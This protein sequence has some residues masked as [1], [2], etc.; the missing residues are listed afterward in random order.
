M[1]LS[2]SKYCNGLQ[3]PKMLW[4]ARNMPEQLDSSVI[5]QQ[6]LDNGSRVG[7]VAM[8]YFGDFVEV[9]YNEKK[10][11]M[12]TETR[13][14]MDSG[15]SVIAEA[16][17]GFDGNFCSVDLLRKCKDHYD[18]IEV[19]SST[20]IK[21][22]YIHDMAYQFYVLTNCGVPIEKIFIM[23]I[24]NEYIRQGA[25]DLGQLFILEDCTE[26]VRL[27]AQQVRQNIEDIKKVAESKTE[28]DID[29]GPHCFD[30]YECVYRGYC[31]RDMPQPNVFEVARLSM[32]KKFELRDKDI[33][34]FEDLLANSIGLNQKQTRQV[35]LEARNLPPEIDKIAIRDFLT[36]LHYPLYFLD[37]ETYQQAVPEFNGVVPYMQIP[38]QFSLHILWKE[39]NELDHYEFLALEGI[40]PR[41]TLAEALCKDIPINVCVL[42]YNMGF[43]KGVIRKL[44]EQFPDL[45]QHLMNIHDNIKDLMTPFQN[46]FY[47]CREMRGSYSIKY[48]LPALFPDDPDLDYHALDGVHNGGEAM[49]AFSDLINLPPEE[50]EIVRKNLLAYCGL[51]TLAMVKILEKLREVSA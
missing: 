49:A 31:W 11:E 1:N 46:H 30:P 17:F 9:P 33:V 27:C 24:N 2:K 14:L 8:G 22:I 10:A 48:V 36:T 23:Y 28:P 41:R 38:F 21:D 6:V 37:F 50:R 43:E 12:I 40:D 16:S 34:S 42:A 35:Q 45:S 18:I 15:A 7:D 20:A 47:Y 4:M 29:I 13:R 26:A 39:N 44:A 5:K 3:C 32:S 25:L 51:D 19:K